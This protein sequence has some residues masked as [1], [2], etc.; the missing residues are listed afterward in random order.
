MSQPQYFDLQDIIAGEQLVPCKT[1]VQLNKLGII[2]LKQLLTD[3]FIIV[4]NFNRFF[5][6]KV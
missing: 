4:I 5:G 6:S 2:F 3:M 1:L